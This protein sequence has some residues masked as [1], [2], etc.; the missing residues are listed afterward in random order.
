M[1]K[2][3]NMIAR[4]TGGDGTQVWVSVLRTAFLFMLTSTQLYGVRITTGVLLHESHAVQLLHGA[5]LAL[6]L[7]S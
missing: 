6:K 5:A 7:P 2:G 4:R 1:A 3:M